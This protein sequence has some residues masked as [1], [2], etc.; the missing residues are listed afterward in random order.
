MRIR[1]KTEYSRTSHQLKNAA[2][3]CVAKNARKRKI[4]FFTDDKQIT[5]FTACRTFFR[6][7]FWK[8]VE[9]RFEPFAG[10]NCTSAR[11]FCLYCHVSCVV[12][13]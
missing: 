7:I 8:F 6:V 13:Q 4:Q 5:S 11:E 10:Y 9:F 3:L 2:K 1:L 12:L